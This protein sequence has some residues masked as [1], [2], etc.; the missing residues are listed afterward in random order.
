MALDLL[1]KLE[2]FLKLKCHILKFAKIRAKKQFWCLKRE[3]K[4]F[5]HFNLYI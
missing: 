3:L 1:L 2:A 4:E 5:N